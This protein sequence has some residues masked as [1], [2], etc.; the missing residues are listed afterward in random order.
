MGK[1][2]G[3]LFSLRIK[4]CGEKFPWAFSSSKQCK[5]KCR[6][7]QKPKKE[8]KYGALWEKSAEKILR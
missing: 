8:E 4:K 1:I 3:K 2:C 5:K 6:K 7:L